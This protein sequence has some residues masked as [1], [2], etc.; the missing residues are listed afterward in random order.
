MSGL[1]V[2]EQ[3]KFLR[4]LAYLSV[5]LARLEAMLNGQPITGIRIKDVAI[6][7]AKM[8]DISADKITSGEI[9]VGEVIYI[10]DVSSGNYIEEND[11]QIIMHKGGIPQAVFGLQ[12]G[13]PIIKIGL[14]GVNALTDT[15]PNNFV[16]Y[17][18][19]STD[20][21]LIK[22]KERNSIAVAAGTSHNIAHGLGYVP[23]TL[24][25]Y[26]SAAGTYR[27]LYGS[28]WA[29]TLP[30]YSLTST[31]LTLVNPTANSVTFYYYLFYDLI[32]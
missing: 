15:D 14:D 7:N 13:T 29:G 28:D 26:L 27:K 18:D 20:Y 2:L 17:F 9:A 6:T 32:A 31:N 22:E 23:F 25:F 16:F 3:A 11:E 21:I 5:R 30:Y 24:V 10:G 8:N 1:N 4:Q 12:S 19:G